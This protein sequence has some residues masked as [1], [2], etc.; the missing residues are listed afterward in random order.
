MDRPPMHPTA[1]ATRSSDGR[2][3]MLLA[4]W[5]G[6]S[7]AA[8]A[9]AGPG[10][11]LLSC[12]RLDQSVCPALKL[13]LA[14]PKAA[15]PELTQV[16]QAANTTTAQ[17][18]KA[19]IALGILLGKDAAGPLY[20]A[21]QKLPDG[22]DARIDLL[23]AAARA[24]SKAPAAELMRVLG[25]AS[26]RNR[27][28][29][30]GALASL[31]HTAAAPKLVPLLTNDRQPRLQAAAANALA[32]VGGKP[33][34]PALVALAAEPRG[35]APARRAALLALAKIGAADGLVTAARLVDHPSRNIGRAALKVIAAAPERWT[36]PLILFALK[37][38]GLRGEAG[39]AAVQMKALGRAVLVAALALDLSSQERTWLL[40]AVTQLKPLGAGMALMDV[41][42]KLDDAGRIDVLKTLPL[43]KDRT[44]VPALVKELERD[45]KPV[46]N[47][48]VYALENLTGERLG[49]SLAAW[50][51]YAGM[52]GA[53][54]GDTDTD[55][56]T[57]KQ[58]K[59]GQPG[60]TQ[61]TSPTP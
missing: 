37:T 22:G 59:L 25:K 53:A 39:L 56:G 61:P 28:V 44:V 18:A 46:A 43:L 50:Q 19:G 40:H 52:K 15:A 38:P 1:H 11:D 32:V 47:Y 49:G 42:G 5:L 8:H 48:V 33:A 55:T 27:V 10:T 58:P 35:F 51:K 57:P 6:C 3:V 9:S 45:R 23:A 21:A 24:G 16:L 30:C 13:A 4:I 29:A 36:E 34:V 26:P 2:R 12:A 7:W 14:A 31:S 17:R 60:A 20:A 54:A 41:F